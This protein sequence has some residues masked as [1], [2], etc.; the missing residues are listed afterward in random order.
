[1]DILI[2]RP[3]HAL[4]K[5]LKNS[6]ERGPFKVDLRTILESANST[7]PAL[8]KA[9]D[10]ANCEIAKNGKASKT[11]TDNAKLFVEAKVI[12]DHIVRVSGMKFDETK[13]LSVV[14]L[15]IA[16]LKAQLVQIKFSHD[17]SE[18]TAQL[19]GK[20]ITFPIASE[21]IETFFNISLPLLYY[22]K[23]TK[24]CIK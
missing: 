2:Q 8:I 23:V 17:Q 10:I 4:T 21:D 15:Q 5:S 12:L 16:G 24:A 1:M 9:Y 13:K 22:W 14:N 19:N 3:Q 7:N 11:T 6:G 18:Y 20:T